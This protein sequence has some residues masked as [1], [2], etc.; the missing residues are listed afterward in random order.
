LKKIKKLNEIVRPIIVVGLERRGP[1]VLNIVL[2]VEIVVMI[3]AYGD[4][5]GMMLLLMLL[6]VT[7]LTL[8]IAAPVTLV[9]VVDQIVLHQVEVVQEMMIALPV[10]LLVLVDQIVLQ[11]VEEVVQEELLIFFLLILS[12]YSKLIY[13]LL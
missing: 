8:M 1:I 4:P 3:T 13:I 9:V 10:T 2:K 11:Q 6:A 7:L 5:V 12:L